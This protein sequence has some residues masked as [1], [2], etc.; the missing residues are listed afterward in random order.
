MLDVAKFR[1]ITGATESVSDSMLQF[2]LDSVE[3][4]ICN[5]CHVTEIPDGLIFTAYRM[6]ADMYRMETFGS[7]AMNGKS[8]AVQSVKTGDTTVSY[9]NPF[10]GKDYSSYMESIMH[11]YTAQ[12]NRYRK[13]VRP[14]CYS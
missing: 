12:L 2:I 10:S 11:N 8:G 4:T 13:L 5:Y 6:A 3:E 7:A 14:S 9:L 1:E